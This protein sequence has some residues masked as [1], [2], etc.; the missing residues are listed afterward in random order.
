MKA[1][2]RRKA[3]CLRPL[4]LRRSNDDRSI[5]LFKLPRRSDTRCNNCAAQI[6]KGWPEKRGCFARR[7]VTRRLNFLWNKREWMRWNRTVFVDIRWISFNYR[8]D[9]V[10]ATGSIKVQSTNCIRD[11]ANNTWLRSRRRRVRNKLFQ[12][13]NEPDCYNIDKVLGSRA[14][15]TSLSKEV[16]RSSTRGVRLRYLPGWFIRE[17]DVGRKKL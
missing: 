15:H 5:L 14:A 11:H 2:G 9:V 16:M 7:K 4:V 13:F 17:K 10:P 1:N 6:G 12:T 8:Y 3:Y